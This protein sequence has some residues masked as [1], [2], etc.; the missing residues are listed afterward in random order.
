MN[1]CERFQKLIEEHLADEISAADREALDAHAA[2]CAECRE[3]LTL[4]QKLAELGDEIPMPAESRFAEMRESV[5]AVS[6]TRG[7]DTQ[8]AKPR[9]FLVDLAHLWQ[10]YPLP[11][12]LATAAV[13]ILAVFLG[14]WSPRSQSLETQ[15]VGDA[16]HWV[17]TEGESLQDAWN[18]PYSFRNVAVRPTPQGRLSLS[19]D[20]SRHVEMQVAQSSPLAREVLLHAILEPTSMG[21]RLSAM[22]ATTQMHDPRL[23]Q[24]LLLTM[25]NDPDPTARI[26]ALSVVARYPYDDA[27]QQA[28]LQ[29]LRQDPDVELRLQVLE[30]LARQGVA[31]QTIRNAVADDDP[32]GSLLLM[33]QATQTW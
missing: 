14:R 7:S 20:A 12:G 31:T 19:F 8:R 1:T 11:A 18:S 22:N 10:S 6:G 2:S 16:S 27:I 13:L 23:E 15:L 17:T 21:S 30:Q 29:S 25:L 32:Y 33:R 5:L 3:L 28:Y 24:A 9:G 4:H 26:N